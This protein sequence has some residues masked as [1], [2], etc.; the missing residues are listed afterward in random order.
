MD[1]VSCKFKNSIVELDMKM[2][3]VKYY[4]FSLKAKHNYKVKVHQVVSGERS[5]ALGGQ[6]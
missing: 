2:P 3:S 1:F 5:I 4:F 6:M